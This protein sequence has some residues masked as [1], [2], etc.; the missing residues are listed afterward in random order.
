MKI[1]E[2][3]QIYRKMMV[4]QRMKM[5][6]VSLERAGKWNADAKLEHGGP[7]Q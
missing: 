4:K 2:H 6:I 7:Q 5:E 3:L 1:I